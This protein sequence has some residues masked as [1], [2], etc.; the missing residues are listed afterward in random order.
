MNIRVK[1]FS[2]V[3]E[4]AGSDEQTVVV[5]PQADAA[6]V[7]RQLVERHPALAP[8]QGSLRMAVNCEYVSLTHPLK[9]GDEVAIIPPVSGG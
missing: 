4:I 7:L 8:W 3:K 5:A 1:L 6:E 2:V 9:E